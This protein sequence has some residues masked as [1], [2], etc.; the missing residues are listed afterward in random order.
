MS[1]A[2]DLAARIGELEPGHEGASIVAIEGRPGAG[3][4]TFGAALARELGATHVDLEEAYP[5][6]SGLEEGSRLALEELI[7][8][9]AAGETAVLPQWDWVASRPA[10]P[11]VVEPSDYLVISGTG[12]GPQA[13]RPCLSLLVWMELDPAEGRRRALERDGAAFAPHWEQW[14]EQVEAH[15]ER[16]H[17][18]ERADAVV[19]TSGAEPVLV[20]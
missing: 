1:A 5:G 3:K 6:W 19:D 16:E 2:G 4:T 7:V 11:L 20:G 12:S 18:R 9:A 13:A 8:P 15:L 17:T 14:S 10:E